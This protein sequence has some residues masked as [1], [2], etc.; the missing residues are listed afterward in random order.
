MPDPASYHRALP[1]QLARMA[2]YLGILAALHLTGLLVL[3]PALRWTLV[4]IIITSAFVPPR[5][6]SLASGIGFLA[7][8]GVAYFH[9]GSTLMGIV[10]GVLGAWN[11]TEAARTLRPR[12]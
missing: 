8:G 7:V 9:Y 11:L 2:I 3:S 4:G 6:S 10:C 12:G 1:G 5:F